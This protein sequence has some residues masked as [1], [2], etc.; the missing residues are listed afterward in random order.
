MDQN[1]ATNERVTAQ[2]I[3]IYLTQAVNALRPAA[4]PLQ[5]RQFAPV[6]I[7][8][9]NDVLL[10]ARRVF[11]LATLPA[12]NTTGAAAKAQTWSIVAAVIAIVVAVVIAVIAAV[13][14]AFSSGVGVSLISGVIVAETA[15]ISAVLTI[16]QGL[17]SVL[18]VVGYPLASGYG[19]ATN[20]IVAAFGKFSSSPRKDPEAAT[21]ALSDILQAV[22]QIEN[23]TIAAASLPGPC[24]GDPQAIFDCCRALVPP[25]SNLAQIVLA[26]QLLNADDARS[27]FSALQRAQ[28]CVAAV[29]LPTVPL[30]V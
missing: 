8:L 7:R 24:S 25:L 18:T 17:T 6:T 15:I 9:L 30:P 28:T 13:V 14:S 22:L 16:V 19:I 11:G 20:Q 10:A 21:A 1:L 26:A 4:S 23:L 29:K 3:P 2:Q 27:A 5:R 12:G